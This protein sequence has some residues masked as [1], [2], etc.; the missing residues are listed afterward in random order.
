MGVFFGKNA[1]RE[2]QQ[3]TYP[4]AH[5]HL[6]FRGACGYFPQIDPTKFIVHQLRNGVFIPQIPLLVLVHIQ[7][8]LKKRCAQAGVWTRGGYIG[9]A[10]WPNGNFSRFV[11]KRGVVGKKVALVGCQVVIPKPVIQVGKPEFFGTIFHS[12]QGDGR[13]TRALYFVPIAIGF[14]VFYCTLKFFAPTNQ[15]TRPFIREVHHRAIRMGGNQGKGISIILVQTFFNTQVQLVVFYGH[16]IYRAT[17]WKTLKAAQ[18]F[19]APKIGRV[20][21]I[22]RQAKNTFCGTG[23]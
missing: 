3:A 16:G 6:I 19:P 12:I 21:I 9:G 2:I 20:D 15:H 4:T 17:L 22:C 18:G 8:I 5:K 1:C 23:V 14:E 7:A 11:V 10:I 13:L